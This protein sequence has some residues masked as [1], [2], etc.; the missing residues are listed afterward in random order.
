MTG[1]KFKWRNAKKS[2]DDGSS[3]FVGTSP[4]FDFAI[5]STC[6]MS[7]FIEEN[8]EVCT[9]GIHGSLLE[10]T[11]KQIF[12]KAKG[13]QVPT[14]K[15]NTAYPLSVVGKFGIVHA[16]NFNNLMCTCIIKLTK[17]ANRL[18]I[19]SSSN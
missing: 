17:H 2:A 9:C 12:T 18:P 7:L 4:A 15:I 8:I 5:F 10:I 1:L 14:S 6:A 3:L 13:K 19:K 16:R 11:A